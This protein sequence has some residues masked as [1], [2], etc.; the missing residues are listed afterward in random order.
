MSMP[1]NIPL[2]PEFAKLTVKTRNRPSFHS[3]I[4][5][6]QIGGEKNLSMR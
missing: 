5:Y 1:V 2:Y 6:L 4:S 3:P